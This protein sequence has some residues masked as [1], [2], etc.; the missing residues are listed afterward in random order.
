MANYTK[1][2]IKLKDFLKLMGNYNINAG[3]NVPMNNETTKTPQ[4]KSRRVEAALTIGYINIDISNISKD[5]FKG[6]DDL[7]SLQEYINDKFI[8]VDFRNPIY[9]KKYFSDLSKQEQDKLL[10][11]V[12]EI[13][14]HHNMSLDEED[15]ACYLTNSFVTK[16]T[17]A[18]GINALCHNNDGWILANELANY[19]KDILKNNN[20]R[21]A[22]T[23]YI[24]CINT[25][26]S[27]LFQPSDSFK[28]T[29]LDFLETVKLSKSCQSTMKRRYKQYFD[30][31]SST[32]LNEVIRENSKYASKLKKFF[33]VMVVLMQECTI[34][35]V[36]THSLQLANIFSDYFNSINYPN[37]EKNEKHKVIE[38][39]IMN[40]RTKVKRII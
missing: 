14:V 28:K 24:N 2:S 12:C 15:F 4:S 22:I 9:N 3:V 21:F 16:Y 36:K 13:K 6:K 33:Y 30:L 32:K 27:N 19:S 29:S 10:N 8:L 31:V 1:E 11:I 18:E 23:C 37:F 39:Q 5:I 38:K 20:E 35:D 7:L 34:Q 40:L 25:Y 26:T 17:K